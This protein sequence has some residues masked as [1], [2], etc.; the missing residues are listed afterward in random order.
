MPESRFVRLFRM[1][2]GMPPYRWVRAFRL[3]QAKELLF[4]SSL[5]LAQIAYDCGFADQSHFTRAFAA[6]TGTTPG[7]WRR[8]RRA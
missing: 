3:E 1:T 6:A 7:A 4:N 8:A 5:S 2:T